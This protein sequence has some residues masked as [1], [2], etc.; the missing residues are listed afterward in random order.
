[1]SAAVAKLA[2]L[3]PGAR[4]YTVADLHTLPEDGPRYELIDGSIIVSP[5]ATGSH[6]MFARWI[7]QLLEEANPDTAYVVGTDQSVTIDE[8]N[9]PRP[10]VVVYPSAHLD[11]SPFPVDGVQLVVEVVSPT[12]ALRDTEVKRVLYARAGV[13]FYW[14]VVPD[15]DADTIA[16]A[17][18]VLEEGKYRYATHYTS[19]V[20]RTQQPWPVEI[21]LP[22]LAA[23]TARYR[24]P[25]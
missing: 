6:N 19:G 17:E 21:D 2:Q 22:A 24:R 11:D 9:E 14:V 8:H 23:R 4:G 18:L 15:S 25:S 1:M 16:L 13:P 7:A 3:R 10:D 12:S 20:F 5:S